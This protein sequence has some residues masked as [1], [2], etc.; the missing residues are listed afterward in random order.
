MSEDEVAKTVVD[1]LAQTQLS[2]SGDGRDVAVADVSFEASR[3]TVRRVLGA[4]G[5]G[6]VRLCS[7]AWIGRD[8]AMKV[9]HPTAGGSQ[10]QTRGRFLREARVQGQLEHPSVVPVYDIGKLGGETFFTM[11]RIGGHALDA[12]VHGLREGDA[13]ICVKYNRRKLLAATSQV[14]LTIAYAHS[15]G[16]IHRDLKPANVMLGDFGEVYVLDWGVAKLREGE[17]V[18]APSGSVRSVDVGQRAVTQ[19][20]AVIGTPGYMAPEQ[21]RGAPVDPRADV[22]ALGAMLFEVLAL[23]PMHRGGADINVLL[24]STLKGVEAPSVRAPNANVPPELD[25]IVARATALDPAERYESARAMH[26]DIE[27]F[28]D[29]ERDAERRRE[30]ASAHVKKAREALSKASHAGADAEALRAEGMRELGRAVA[31]DPSDQGALRAISELVLAP[32]DDL[33]ASAV[34]ELKLGERADRAKGAARAARMYIVW[35]GMVPLLFFMGIRSW[36]IVVALASLILATS[37]YAQFVGSSPERA[38]PQRL[39]ASMLLNAALVGTCSLIFGPLVF[40]PGI[41]ASSAAAYVLAVREKSRLRLLPFSL[42]TCSV[43]VPLVLQ[44]AGVLPA[45]Y[46]FDGGAITIHPIVAAFR[47]ANTMVSLA[48]VTFVQLMLPSVLINRAV[49]SLVDAERRSFAQAWRLRQLLP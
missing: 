24:G 8:V 9:A 14:C 45:S 49:D 12:V 11:K 46:T 4:G 47:P 42:A 7:D 3:Y 21:L 32:A 23:E 35:L 10:S 18:A 17:D 27:A 26:E 6:E 36:P 13:E 38:T 16:V 37:A 48:L 43:F 20:G 41:A 15:R 30:L 29:G 39:F 34:A 31:L 28:L 25:A 1:S 22:Y 2:E 44:Y 19:D 5:M 33:P 40:V